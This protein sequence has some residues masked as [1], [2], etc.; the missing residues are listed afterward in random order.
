MMTCMTAKVS[1]ASDQQNVILWDPAI[2]P[3]IGQF[4]VIQSVAPSLGMEAS[5]INVRDPAELE[6]RVAS[7]ARTP[8][9][10]LIVTA[11]AQAVVHRNVIITA[12]ANHRL[13]A[14]YFARQFV[15]GGGLISY[16]SD[17]VDQHRRAATYIDR[18]LKGEK[19]GDLPVQAPTE[20]ELVISLKTAKMLGITMPPMLLARA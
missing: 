13:P 17:W 16:G 5:P 10:G 11:S 8:N 4:A 7:F 3:G 1:A 20:Y 15:T 19:P 12:A 18:I 2:P 14:V 9:G 6:R